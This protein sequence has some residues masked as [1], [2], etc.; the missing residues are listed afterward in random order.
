VASTNK[1]G[2]GVVRYVAYLVRPW[3]YC[4]FKDIKNHIIKDGE[5]LK[6]YLIFNQNMC[7]KGIWDDER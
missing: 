7:A 6:F 5:K 4:L 2:E 3:M 1:C